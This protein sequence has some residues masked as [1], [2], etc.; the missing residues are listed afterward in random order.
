MDDGSRILI[1]VVGCLLSLL[2]M[3]FLTACESAVTEL[4]DNKLKKDAEG[5]KR[6]QRLLK[7]L[8]KPNRLMMASSVARSFMIAAFAL[9][10]Q[11]GFFY[12]LVNVIGKADKGGEFYYAICV[13]AA[14]VIIVLSAFFISTLGIILPRRAVGASNENG[15]KFAYS[16]AALYN[17][18]LCLWVPLEKCASAVVNGILRLFGVKNLS[19]RD[20]VTE[21][22]ILLMVDAVNETGAIEE[23]QSEMIKN[24]F[25]FD[26]REVGDVMTHRT[27]IYAVEINEPV[28]EAVKVAVEDGFSRIPVYQGTI[29]RICGAVF[30]KDLLKAYSERDINSLS[31]TEIMRDIV[32][33]PETKNCGELFE[34]FTAHRNQ[35][36]VV[37]DEYG[38][39][40]G[41][42]TMEDLLEEIVG[43]IRDEYDDDE[44][45]EIDE[46][47][48]NTFDLLATADFEEVMQ[49][50]DLS[51]DGEEEYDTI[52][53]F[54]LDMLGRFPEENERATV[55][56]KSVTFVV[57][58]ALDN[59]IKKIRAFKAKEK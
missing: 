5:D 56:Y 18:V 41:I 37:V 10:A 34:E 14:F 59:K 44:E 13:A 28:S 16:V 54:F 36:A 20:A 27:N 40:A 23:S 35:I 9:I 49:R 12:P 45:E 42:V 15:E 4:N 50:L 32:Y 58:A 17:A 43:N 11:I 51:F 19:A 47:T 3:G 26:D 30:A 29:D 6:A 2:L 39:T 55:T 38:G 52:G 7:L 24:V 53:A 25:E 33:V 31:L 21:E 1:G 22:E 46:I 8:S 48:P 57:I